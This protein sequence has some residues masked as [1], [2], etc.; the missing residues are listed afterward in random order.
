[1]L[2]GGVSPIGAGGRAGAQPGRFVPGVSPTLRG[3]GWPGLGS[4][5]RAQEPVGMLTT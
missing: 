1:M 3:E 2:C 4:P 5:L